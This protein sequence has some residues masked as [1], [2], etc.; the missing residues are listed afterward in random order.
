MKSDKS[1][2]LQETI[3]SLEQAMGEWEA[4][5]SSVETEADEFRKKTKELI[6]KLNEQI[7]A[8]DL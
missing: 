3:K 2:P 4:I 8:L 6:V 1:L 5:S 7:K